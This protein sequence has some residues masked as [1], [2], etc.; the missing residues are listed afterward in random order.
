M[1]PDAAFALGALVLFGKRI[2]TG[3]KVFLVAL[4]IVDDICAI[5]PQD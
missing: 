3:L 2:P 5:I 1:A 4:A